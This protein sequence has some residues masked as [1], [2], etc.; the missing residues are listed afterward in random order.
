MRAIATATTCCTRYAGT[1]QGARG[2]RRLRPAPVVSL[3]DFS[4]H[5]V[6]PWSSTSWSSAFPSPACVTE[7]RLGECLWQ[8][9]R[10]M[11][12]ARRARLGLSLK[13][14]I[15]KADKEAVALAVRSA[16]DGT[17]RNVSTHRP[18]PLP[19]CCSPSLLIL[20]REQYISCSLPAEAGGW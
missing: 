18:L 12:E 11:R 4:R 14:A 3:L 10:R 17:Q 16:A 6:D 19:H 20:C 5:D 15:V 1:L 7:R 8:Y 9:E 2:G 13:D